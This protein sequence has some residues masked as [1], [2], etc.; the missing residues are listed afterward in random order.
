MAA[1]LYTPDGFAKQIDTYKDLALSA[2]NAIRNK[3]WDDNVSVASS[4]GSVTNTV[5]FSGCFVVLR[6]WNASLNKYDFEVQVPVSLGGTFSY[7]VPSGKEV[8]EIVLFLHP[9]AS[10]PVAG[11][12]KVQ[13]DFASDSSLE[14]TS[15]GIYNWM[16]WSSK[17][18][19]ALDTTYT[20]SFIQSSGDVFFTYNISLASNVSQFTYGFS[21][22]NHVV[23][24][25][26]I[27]GRFS[28]N[29]SKLSS[30]SAV[31]VTSPG[32]APSDTDIQSGIASTTTQIA[33]SVNEV[34]ESIQQLMQHISN[35]LAAL[36][37]QI[38]NYCHV[39]T[40]NKLQEILLSIQNISMGS[41]LQKIADQISNSTTEQTND[42]ISNANSN[43][44]KTDQAIQKHGNFIIEGLKSLFIPSDEYFNAKFSDLNE[45]FKDR[46]G[47]LYTP[48]DLLVRFVNLIYGAS[49]TFDGIPFPELSWDG[50]VL[51][52]AQTVKFDILDI[53]AFKQVQKY[54]YFLTDVMMIGALVSLIHRKF[55]EVMQN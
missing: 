3:S 27:G 54:L 11:Q 51:L 41:D 17:N 34:Y 4:V 50:H 43:Q 47:F 37:D 7:V 15:K 31:N 32:Q 45:F 12:Y 6:N 22:K 20:P 19:T 26:A 30:G 39:P 48:I 2:S 28:I 13:V 52:A 29:F 40:Y 21:I 44:E 18:Q 36:W 9:S 42:L 10:L 33:S 53:A 24:G 46:F 8:G 5:D 1:E 16:R 14:Y 38:Y 25:G 49:N 55:E 35:Q 23:G